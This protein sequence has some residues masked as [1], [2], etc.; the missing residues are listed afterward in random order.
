MT[1]IEAS[2]SSPSSR[3]ASVV[4]RV[5]GHTHGRFIAVLCLL[6]VAVRVLL[7]AGW[8]SDSQIVW[9][10]LPVHTV[11][12]MSAVVV[13]FLV[14]SV[15]W[16]AGGAGQPGN[17]VVIGC[18]YLAVGLIDMGH[19]LSYKGMPDLVTPSGPEKAIQFWIVARYVAALTLL[20]ASGRML[21]LASAAWRYAGLAAA[22]VLSLL[23]YGVGLC[24]PQWWPR[25]FIEGSGLTPF[26][27]A[28][29]YGVIVITAGAAWRF[30]KVGQREH[31]YNTADLAAA[32]WITILSELCLTL[33]GNVFDLYSLLG[34]AYKIVAYFFIYKAV[35]VTS[36]RD[37]YT[38]LRVE[39]E[40]RREAEQRV[41]F[42]AYHDVLTHLPNRDLARDRWRQA[43]ADANRRDTQVALVFLDID[44]FKTINDSL[45]HAIGDRFLQQVA[46]CL[47][48]NV[49]ESDTVS[50]QGG[51]EFL[52]ILKDLPD[53]DAATP[54]VSKLLDELSKP[55][56]VDGRELSATASIGI[57]MAPNDGTDFEALSQRADTAM[58]RAKE[59]GRNTYRFFDDRMNRE[60]IERLTIR[61]DL[62]RALEQQQFALYYQPQLDLRTRRVIG[63]EA[64]IRW[65]HPEK[66]LVS[67]A[68]FIPVAEES[69][70]IVPMGDWVIAEAARQV[71]AWRREGLQLGTVAVNLSALQFRRGNLE[72][73]VSQALAQSGL[74]AKQLELELTESVLISDSDSVEAR[75]SALKALGV[76]VSIDDFGTGYSSLAYLRR[77]SVDKLKIDQ[78]FIR[79]LDRHPD[80]VGIVRAIIQMAAS[81]GLK[82]IAEG[83]ETESS[84]A[85]LTELGCDEVQGYLFARPMP[86]DELAAWLRARADAAPGAQA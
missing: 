86:A 29:E 15:A 38:R 66:G 85:L 3:H 52:L 7:A 2:R 49:R 67:P 54:I 43:L 23:V 4:G 10:P 46:E 41:E 19:L 56:M 22:V 18:G 40:E 14:F 25:T 47:R 31:S 37:P 55:M 72:S 21:P 24:F 84:A 62:R 45:G 76:K 36:V 42:L 69:G 58:Y 51:D 60:S 5:V 78:S 75:L 32:A 50:R 81:M 83:V 33:Y 8:L 12:E 6:L 63:L 59:E 71:V 65:R 68:A 61:Q 57:A 20:G 64:L 30:Y 28:A 80:D 73:V 77:F 1:A 34:H 79:D 27:L 11:M 17:I 74:P 48:A 39:V 53:A 26:K 35:F 82:T 70:L 9:F 44:H 13:A 16:H